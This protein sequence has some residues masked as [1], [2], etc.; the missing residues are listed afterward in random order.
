MLGVAGEYELR[1]RVMRESHDEYV[2]VSWPT[3]Y[4]AAQR[5]AC[6]PSC[7]ECMAELHT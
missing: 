3:V 4:A 2:V 5:Q 7:A 6:L 1:V